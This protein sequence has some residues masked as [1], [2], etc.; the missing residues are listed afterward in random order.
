MLDIT[1]I[2]L[3]RLACCSGSGSKLTVQC[4]NVL[5]LQYDMTQLPFQ[6]K[7]ASSSMNFSAS[8]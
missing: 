5:Y 2:R 3:I 7:W 4:V 6:K 8:N 1:D